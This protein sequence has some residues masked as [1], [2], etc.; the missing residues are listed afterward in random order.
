MVKHMH[1]DAISP[2]A[3]DTNTNTEHTNDFKFM[4]FIADSL[5]SVVVYIQEPPSGTQP[6][7]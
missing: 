6:H 5:Y 4:Q 3:T 2:Q 7:V 1:D